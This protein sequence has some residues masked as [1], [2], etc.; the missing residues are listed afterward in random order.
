MWIGGSIHLPITSELK[1]IRE[2]RDLIFCPQLC[3]LAQK[4]FICWFVFQN[5]HFINSFKSLSSNVS[6]MQF[7]ILTLSWRAS[8]FKQA[9]AG[10]VLDNWLKKKKDHSLFRYTFHMAR[11]LILSSG[12]VQPFTSGLEDMLQRIQDKHLSCF[13]PGK[14]NKIDGVEEMLLTYLPEYNTVLNRC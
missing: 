5:L 12:S 7:I 10:W 4:R 13:V 14:E 1:Q 3:S 11:F 8:F 2:S 9:A 6:F